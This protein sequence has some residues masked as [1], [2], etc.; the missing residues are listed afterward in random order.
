MSCAAV[1]KGTRQ[2]VHFD[3]VPEGADVRID[4]QYAGATPV[5][6]EVHR[7]SASNILVSKDGYRE[8]YVPVQRHPDTPWWFWD[9]GTCVIPV[10]LCIPILVDA[11]S[12]AWYSYEDNVRVKLEPLA[13]PTAPPTTTA[14]NRP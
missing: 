3:A 11:I 5:D 6:V 8:Q 12:G 7:S 14:A 4:G 13:V 2:E 9:I 1:F 10:T